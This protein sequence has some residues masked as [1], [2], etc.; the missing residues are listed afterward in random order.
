MEHDEGR[1]FRIRIAITLGAAALPLAL[2]LI[3]SAPTGWQYRN[4]VVATWA[5]MIAVAACT[6]ALAPSFV[7]WAARRELGLCLATAF[8]ALILAYP[9]F[10]VLYGIIYGNFSETIWITLVAAGTSIHVALPTA[11]AFAGFWYWR[12][13]ATRDQRPLRRVAG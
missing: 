2:S 9:L 13:R 5:T 11:L 6:Y 3:W 1:M 8:L 7:R 12:I 4:M 10:S